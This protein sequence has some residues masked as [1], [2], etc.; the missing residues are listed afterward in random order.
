MQ[1]LCGGHPNGDWRYLQWRRELTDDEMFNACNAHK[2]RMSDGYADN[3][4]LINCLGMPDPDKNT[5]HLGTHPNNLRATLLQDKTRVIFKKVG[6]LLL[7]HAPI[8]RA[9]QGRSRPLV[10][11]CWCRS[12]F[13]RSVAVTT[14]IFFCLRRAGFPVTIPDHLCRQWWHEKC[15]RKGPCHLCAPQYLDGSYWQNQNKDTLQLAWEMWQ[16][17]C[18]QVFATIGL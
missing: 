18:P 3:L 1:A 4:I 11:L 5:Y 10:L 7:D 15:G 12:G 14:G 2:L 17:V 6:D 9:S 16:E 8:W 13:H